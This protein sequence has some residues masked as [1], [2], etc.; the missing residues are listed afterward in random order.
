MNQY[1]SVSKTAGGA[2]TKFAVVYLAA[3]GDAEVTT[4]KTDTPFGIALEAAASG[5][6]VNIAIAGRTY[7]V[8]TDAA[9]AA[10]EPLMGI[11]SG[12]VDTFDEAAGAYSFAVAL[13]DSPATDDIV[14]VYIYGPQQSTATA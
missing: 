10:G 5:E 6:K 13:E 12:E 2:I 7:A 3:D 4:A 14:Q 1:Y 8:A 9:V 11:A